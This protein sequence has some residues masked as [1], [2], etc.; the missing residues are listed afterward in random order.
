MQTI[1][2]QSIPS[3]EECLNFLRSIIDKIYDD[4][5]YVQPEPT[6]TTDTLW[7]LYE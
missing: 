3:D 7:D 4:K 5:A 1:N 2:Q 6:P